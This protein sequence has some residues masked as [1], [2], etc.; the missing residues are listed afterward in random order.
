MLDKIG[1]CMMTILFMATSGQAATKGEILFGFKPKADGQW[2]S[3]NDGVM[4]GLSEGT[5]RITDKGILEFSGNLSL[6]NRGGFASIRSK[7]TNLGLSDDEAVVLRVRGDGRQ[8]FCNLFVPD[9]R[10]A[11]SYR[12]AFQTKAGRWQEIRLPFKAFRATWFGR[13]LPDAKPVDLSKVNSIG[14]ILA[15]KK[16]GPFRLE[17]DWIKAVASPGQVS[18][19]PRT[20]KSGRKATP[21][22]LA[23]TV[24]SLSGERV[25]LKRYLGK[26][27]LIVNVASKCGLTPQYEQLQSL[28]EKY[29]DKGLAILGF[30]C[31]QFGNQE[32]GTADEIK[33][34]CRVNYGVTFDMFAKINVNGKQASPLYKYLTALQIKPKGAGKINWNFEKFLIGRSGEVLARFAPRTKLDA[35]ELLKA[36]ER[37]LAKE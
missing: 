7:P 12:T 19:G 10:N 17:I 9:G 2:R 23:F 24:Q 35:P 25:D 32:P 1:L 34:F 31:N 18:A 13:T 26:V 8:Y 29:S 30:P 20:V 28:H 6:E 22:A 14:V 33:Q 5:F 16:A 27:V 37:E 4:G 15:D 3:I 21:A 36:L 11:F